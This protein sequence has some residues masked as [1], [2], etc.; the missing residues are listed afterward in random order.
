MASSH[1]SWKWGSRQTMNLGH[2]TP[3]QH[4]QLLSQSWGWFISRRVED[5]IL[6]RGTVWFGLHSRH[7]TL[8]WG[9]VLLRKCPEMQDPADRFH[10]LSS[11]NSQ[12]RGSANNWLR[13]HKLFQNWGS[14]GKS[15]RQKSLR[16][17]GKKCDQM[18]V[19]N[20]CPQNDATGLLWWLSGKE[21]NVGD[22]GLLPCLERSQLKKKKRQNDATK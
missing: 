20:I 6:R 7:A 9:T 8:P 2:L 13:E 21:S 17:G 19:K 3:S 5:M 15:Q 22:M 11:G 1:A 12:H 14:P 10:Q 18:W 4:S 16:K